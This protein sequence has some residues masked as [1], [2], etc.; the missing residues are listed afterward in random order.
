MGYAVTV[1]LGIAGWQLLS[2]FKAP[3]ATLLG[4]MLFIGTA[5]IAG[6][7]LP[8]LP[9]Y[10]TFIF[11]ITLGLFVGARIDREKLSIFTSVA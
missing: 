2:Y 5:K 8:L 11:Q 9:P 10:L 4:P 3:V 7:T 6:L 1:L